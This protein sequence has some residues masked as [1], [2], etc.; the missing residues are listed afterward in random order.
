M[1]LVFPSKVILRSYHSALTYPTASLREA[2]D[3]AS[4]ED[5]ERIHIRSLMA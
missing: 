2:L 3:I 4:D 5:T 1:R